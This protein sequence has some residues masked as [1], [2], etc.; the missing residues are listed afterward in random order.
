MCRKNS[1]QEQNVEYLKQGTPAGIASIRPVMLHNF[2]SSVS[3]RLEICF[4]FRGQYSKEIIQ[5][6]H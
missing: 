4:K 1:N 6:R 5:I 2:R 3:F